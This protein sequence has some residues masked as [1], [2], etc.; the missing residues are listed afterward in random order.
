M[1]GTN[2]E[3]RMAT[4]KVETPTMVKVSTVKEYAKALSDDIR[5]S[6]DFCDALNTELA[7]T[8]EKAIK[9]AKENG[10]GTIQPRD[11]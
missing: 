4:K 2:V 5:V 9:R 6:S 8:V 7:Q 11:L 3:D 10:R 1:T